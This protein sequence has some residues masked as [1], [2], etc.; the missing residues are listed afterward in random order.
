[1]IYMTQVFTKRLP[2]AALAAALLLGGCSDKQ[3]GTNGRLPDS[4][5]DAIGFRTIGE[6]TRAAETDD[7]N[8]ADFRV[9][10]MWVRD[11]AKGDYRPGYLDGV[12]V[13][14]SGSD[15]VYS[16][17]RYWPAA[18]SVDFY[19]YSPAGS[20]GVTSYA[21]GAAFDEVTIGYTA[22]TDHRLQEDF[23]V[24]SA[25]G[26]TANPVTM[27]FRHALSQVEFR[28]RSGAHGVAFRIRAIRL[29]N[30]DREGTLTGTIA[31]PGDAEMEW[32]WSDNTASGEKTET[33]AVYMPAPFT[34][35]YPADATVKPDFVSLTDATV[36]NL[37]IMPQEVTVGR[38]EL[39]T[40]E[41]ID[42][43]EDDDITHGM[44]GQPHD[45]DRRFYIAVTLDSETVYY[46]GTG[47]IPFHSNATIY[48]PL[49]VSLG[50]DG[51]PG[52]GDDVPF[53]FEMGRKYTFMLELN[54]LDQV[55]FTVGETGWSTVVDIPLSGVA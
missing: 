42:A 32:A 11:A 50:A 6:K 9:S 47:T 55:V 51:L 12:K 40:Q 43:D 30:L 24:A 7:D 21:L 41:E 54:D 28:A 18:G 22:T 3:V 2:V 13:E 4:S 53:E 20:T 26:Q 10:A 14:R 17:L 36:G 49:S 38:C 5:Q 8:I 34:V 37:M 23:L 25:L 31:N 27:N 1:M 46:P 45:A 44:L 52:G 48:I 33:Y 16:P 39:Y 35:T 29:L 15:W 19:G